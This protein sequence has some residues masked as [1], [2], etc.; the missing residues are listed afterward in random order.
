MGSSQLV[1]RSASDWFLV[2]SDYPPDQFGEPEGK[3]ASTMVAS[4]LGFI[5][6]GLR[7]WLFWANSMRLFSALAR[8]IYNQMFGINNVSPSDVP[9]VLPSQPPAGGAVTF[10]P[11][12]TSK[13][14]HAEK[15]LASGSQDPAPLAEFPPI[16]STPCDGMSESSVSNHSMPVDTPTRVC[17]A[18]LISLDGTSLSGL[19]ANACNGKHVRG[20]PLMASDKLLRDGTHIYP[21]DGPATS[22]LCRKNS[23]LYKD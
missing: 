22:Y 8:P 17:Q 15:V 21:A 20:A 10:P 7:T 2:G 13:K 4:Y 14:V 1:W 6:I 18:R 11:V 12:T 16:A 3:I 19:T 23:Q 9:L 5:A